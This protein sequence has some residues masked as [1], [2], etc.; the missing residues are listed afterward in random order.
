MDP[1]VD[2]CRDVCD[3]AEYLPPLGERT[4]HYQRVLDY[5]LAHPE[6][7]NRIADLFAAHVRQPTREVRMSI[8]LL[9]FCM[10]TLKWPEVKRAVERAYKEEVNGMYAGELQSLLSV[11]EEKA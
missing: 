6:E 11:Y 10:R 4:P 1:F 8:G 5:I 3:K 7:R 9:R 2:L